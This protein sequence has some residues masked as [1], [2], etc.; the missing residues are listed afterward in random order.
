MAAGLIVTLAVDAGYVVLLHVSIIRSWFILSSQQ[1]LLYSQSGASGGSSELTTSAAS[2]FPNY[3]SEPIAAVV[4]T[5]P[6]TGAKAGTTAM[7]AGKTAIAAG[8]AAAE[9]NATASPGF[10][11]IDVDDHVHP[12]P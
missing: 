1:A 10:M 6:A 11:S 9:T 5:K 7:A 8:A 4:A 2:L 3:H 12:C